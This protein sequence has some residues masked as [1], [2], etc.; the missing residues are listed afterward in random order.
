MKLSIILDIKS[1]ITN[2]W[3]QNTPTILHQ[4]WKC[5]LIISRYEIEN[6]C[7]SPVKRRKKKQH[8]NNNSFTFHSIRPHTQ[9]Q[10]K[11]VR[12]RVRECVSFSMVNLFLCFSIAIKYWA[13]C[14][15]SIKQIWLRYR[16]QYTTDWFGSFRCHFLLP[17]SSNWM[18][19]IFCFI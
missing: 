4:I 18:L 7:S 1:C 2:H 13:I 19:T 16:T 6:G 15:L 3:D 5:L 9:Y 8:T 12:V 10:W 17:C 14:S 11:Y